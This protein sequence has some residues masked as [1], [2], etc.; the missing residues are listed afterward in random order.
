MPASGAPQNFNLGVSQTRPSYFGPYGNG[1]GI[2]PRRGWDAGT[3][4]FLSY[5]EQSPI[6][7]LTL[8]SS[9]LPHRLL[10][11]LADI[12]PMIS[13]VRSN[14]L[15]LA[16]SPGDTRIVAV[17]LAGKD[18]ETIDGPGTAALDALWASLPPETGGL[19][20]LQAALGDMALTCGLCTVEAV[21]GLRGQGLADIATFDPLTVRF[22]DDAAGR[23][24]QQNQ[25]GQWKGLDPAR[26][27][28]KGVDSSR[29]NPYGRPLFGAALGEALNDIA[30]QQNLREVL[31]AAAWP[32]LSVGFPFEEMIAFAAANPALTTGAGPGG[33]DLTAVEFAQEQFSAFQAKIATLK[34]DDVLIYPKNGMVDALSVGAGLSG[35]EGILDRQR[36]R[37][38][39]ALDELPG[40]VGITDGGTQSYTSVQWGIRAKKLEWLRGFVNGLLVSVASLHLKL[41]GSTAVARAET[42]PIKTS[43]ALAVAQA[44][45]FEIANEKQLVVMGLQ[46]QDDAAHHLTG[47]EAAVPLTRE[48]IAAVPVPVAP[49]APAGSGKADNQ[50]T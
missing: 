40:M 5:A 1:I 7:A 10:A 22:I 28:A 32:R 19:L 13:Q 18:G 41:L 46:S 9:T 38:V 39:M 8:W 36:H 12:H 25:G 29:D 37:L 43:D 14:N 6:A 47:S 44:R 16:F 45:S 21:P 50:P 24:L 30:I 49:A 2:V 35:L 34:A 42:K 26:C 33:R 27:F 17:S 3:A 31:R 15:R 4:A 11:V 20:G 23:H 48:E